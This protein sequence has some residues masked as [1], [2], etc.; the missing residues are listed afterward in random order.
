MRFHVLPDDIAVEDALS[1]AAVPVGVSAEV[2]DEVGPGGIELIVKFATER[3]FMAVGC[4]VLGNRCTTV[5]VV[6]HRCRGLLLSA[7]VQGSAQLQP[8]LAVLAGLE[9]PV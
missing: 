2:I 4:H 8:Y 1:C 9:E 6:V 5:Y 7:S 3:A